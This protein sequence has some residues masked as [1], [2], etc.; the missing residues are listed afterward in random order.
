MRLTVQNKLYG[1]FGIAIALLLVISVIA[2]SSL[3]SVAGATSNVQNAAELDDAVMS[4]KIALLTGMDLESESLIR[5][6]REELRPA[7]DETVVEFD[8]ALATL[9]SQ[10]TDNVRAQTEEADLAHAAFQESVLGTFSLLESSGTGDTVINV[11]GRQ[12]MLS[13]K[14]SKEALL[15]ASGDRS[16]G[17]AL[18]A[19]AQEFDQTLTDLIQGNA[20]R[21]I[22]AAAGAVPAQLEKVR[23]LWGPLY[24]QVQTVAS[25][26]AGSVRLQGAVNYISANNVQLLTEMNTA[27]GMYQAQIEDA[28]ANAVDNTD[29]A[30]EL[31]GTLLGQVEEEV[32]AFGDAALANANSTKSSSST[33]VI[34]I[35]AIAVL[36]AAALAWFISRG[37]VGGVNKMKTAAAGIAEG[38]LKQDVA[39]TSKDEIGEMAA[40]F[41]DMIDYLTEMAG[42]AE[43]VADGD[44]TAEV[45]PK[46]QQDLLGNAFKTMIANLNT[47]MRQTANTAE[48]LTV[49]KEQLAST[50]EQSASATQEVASSSQQVAEGTSNQA[51]AAQEV[52]GA[53]QELS[54]AVE[55]ITET[56]ENRVGKAAVGMAEGAQEAAAGARD[57]AKTAEEGAEMVEKTV[58]G[59]GRIKDSMA[60]AS[61]EIGTLGERSA[62]IGKI[63]AVIEDI[64]AQTNL[65]ALNAAIEAARA[66]EQGRGFA[67]VADEV[68]QLAERVASATKE[69]ATLIDGVQQGVD[70]SVKAMEDGT[71]EMD[72]GAAIAAQ[73]GEALAQI[74]AAANGVAQQVQ[75]IADSAAEV[76]DASGEMTTLL[77]GART[78][79]E[80]ITES[81]G[82][83]AAVAE[84]NSASTEEM[85][86]AAEEMSAQVEEVTAATHELGNMADELRAQVAQFKL[87]GAGDETRTSVVELRTAQQ[88]SQQAEASE[89]EAA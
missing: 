76:N 59:I 75:G 37:I 88:A 14:M 25:A 68:R 29:P 2:Y 49:A 7:F 70:G 13:Q 56:A 89:Q 47:A 55:E 3:S 33:L 82:S 84:E 8:A 51:T 22:P 69:I 64:A 46:S 79:V 43:S 18:T 71:T 74:L 10:G 54:R 81:M 32:E 80:T 30:F 31:A 11:A 20:E 45:E 34:A 23:T 72:A 61:V 85:S 6:F 36:A 41:R 63:V 26:S 50:A 52:S 17:A 39:V 48:S 66:G 83:I 12:R 35:S 27:V 73:A 67:V 60:A 40:S 57:S 78:T 38:D 58:E 86:S 65:L 42:A 16:A 87:A 4:M 21:G 24:E 9:M 19:T 5:G 77:D 44:L 28:K 53:T 62:E 1:G 15:I